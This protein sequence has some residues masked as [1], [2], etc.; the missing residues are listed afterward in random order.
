M[1][2]YQ[3]VWDTTR[4]AQQPVAL[5]IAR[6]LAE[7]DASRVELVLHTFETAKVL[8]HRSDGSYCPTE[9]AKTPE[10][11]AKLCAEAK[12]EMHAEAW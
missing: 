3:E 5:E 7:P 1:A 10:G 12:I 11:L 9:A 4:S 8:D 2:T 6:A